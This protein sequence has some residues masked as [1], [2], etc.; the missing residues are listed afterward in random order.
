MTLRLTFLDAEGAGWTVQGQH[1]EPMLRDKLQRFY[2][3]LMESAWGREHLRSPALITE[4]GEPAATMRLYDI[5]FQ[6]DGRPIRV[7]G[8]G[9]VVVRDD[10]RNQ[11]DSMCFQLEKLMKEHED[12]LQDTDKEPLTKAI[13]KVREACKGDDAPAIKSAVEELEQASHALSK[14]LY[15]SGAAAA[16]GPDMGGGPQAPPPGDGNGDGADSADDDAIDAE[17]EVKKE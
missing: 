4:D 7:G 8:I 14:V 15:E 12:K 5:P 2:R 6:L 13:E 17:F 10:L 1:S 9:N 3:E 11:G 16:G